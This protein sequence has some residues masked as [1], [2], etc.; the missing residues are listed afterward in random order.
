M[1][2]KF[3]EA[4][5]KVPGSKGRVFGKGQEVVDIAAALKQAGVTLK[6]GSEN[7]K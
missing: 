7:E 4:I 1:N 6:S 3:G 5:K 2:N